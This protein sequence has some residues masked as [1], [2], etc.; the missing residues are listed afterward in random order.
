VF[1]SSHIL[2]EVEAVCDRIAILRAG[3]LAEIGTLEQMRHL[4]ALQID[5]DME[6]TVP[7]LT[8]VPGV[9]G[10]TVEGT[11]L[12]CRVT[13]SVEPLITVLARAGV[14]HLVSREPSLE[15]LFLAHS[16]AGDHTADVEGVA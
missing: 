1:L 13:G 10:V 7:D 5:A 15:E 12:R 16:G 6:S 14:R 2:S 11:H 9:T 4:S 8:A 3:R